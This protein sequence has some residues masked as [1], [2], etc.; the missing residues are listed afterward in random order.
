M[1][2]KAFRFCN[3]QF[4][5]EKIKYVIIMFPLKAPGIETLK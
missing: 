5:S 2:K 1:K 4:T 3:R